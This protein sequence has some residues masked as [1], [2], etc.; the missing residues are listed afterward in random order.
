MIALVD[1]EAF[2]ASVE[3]ALNPEL[4]GKP[5]II[6][7]LPGTRGIVICASYEARQLGVKFGMTLAEA[8][9]ALPQAVFLKGDIKI[10]RDLWAE[11]C[12]IFA[13]YTP[14]VEPVSMDEAYLD[15]TDSLLLHG[16][17]ETLSQELKNTIKQ[18]LNVNCRLSLRLNIFCSYKNLH[19]SNR[20]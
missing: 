7:G 10:Y 18:R 3:Q 5:V 19:L 14:L 11:I 16:S 4:A 15:L 9:R 20:L 2:L 12:D 8:Y 17:I 1:M 6:G 13:A